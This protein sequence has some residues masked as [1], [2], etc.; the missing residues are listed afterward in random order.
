MLFKLNNVEAASVVACCLFSSVFNNAMVTCETK[1]FW[2]NFEIISV[3]YFTCNHHQ[4]LVVTCEIKHWNVYSF[5]S[6]HVDT[7]THPQTDAAETPNVL[8]YTTTL[9]NNFIIH[10]AT[11]RC[12]QY[13]ALTCATGF[14]LLFVFLISSILHPHPALL[15]RHTLIL[16]HM[17]TFLV[18][19]SIFVLK[20]LFSNFSLHSHLSLP[21]P[22][23]E[24]WPAIVWQSLVV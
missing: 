18:A 2:N 16:G 12:F 23:M 10:P 7:Q 4:W 8:R 11:D 5:R 6:Y 21:Q 15:H 22:D 17:L 1:L 3:S 20:L 24:L 9:G 13:A 14:L 19:F